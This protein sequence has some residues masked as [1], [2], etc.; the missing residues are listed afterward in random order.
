VEPAGRK[1]KK[2]YIK[3][4]IMLW[5]SQRRER[6]RLL[7]LAEKKKRKEGSERKKGK[8]SKETESI[9]K[10]SGACHLK[11]EQRGRRENFGTWKVGGEGSKKRHQILFSQNES[12]LGVF[13]P[14][15]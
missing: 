8:G 7:M 14:F 3:T 6:D 9:L 15:P 11:E 5:Y 1:K 12:L 10:G 13:P 4:L 2:S